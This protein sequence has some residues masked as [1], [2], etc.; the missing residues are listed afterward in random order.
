M[1]VW[2]N[3]W[4]S[5]V[6][7]LINL[8]KQG[9]PNKFTVIGS[10]ENETVVYKNA[11]DEWYTEPRG[12]TDE[13]YV[14]F[15]LGFCKEHKIDVFAPRKKLLAISKSYDRFKELGVILMLDDQYPLLEMLED[16]AR[17]YEY[18]AQ[19]VPECVPSFGIARSYGEFLSCYEE[20]SKTASRVCYKLVEDEGARSFRVVDNRIEGI[21]ALLEKPG[22]KVTLDTA[23]KILSQYD[24]K[25]P[26]LLMPYLSGVEVS[27]DC[28]Q[29]P[30][31]NIII[32]RY[33]TNK[34]YS[35]IIFD[36]KMMS[37]CNKILDSIA[38]KSP[39]NIQFK[40]EGDKFYL[41][42]INPRMSGGLQ[43]SCE[44]TGINLPDVAINKAIG[45]NKAWKYP[46]FKSQRVVHIET[47]IRL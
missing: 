14:D 23:K 28:L 33:K 42:E 5:T 30:G 35:E 1:R 44:A 29:T 36:E 45:E 2:F 40:F 18:F 13:E 26:L 8:I 38:L 24:F 19:I 9:S 11:C 27:V 37:V 12:L 4:F 32:P 3:H 6:F 41:L 20:L 17:T 7:H 39:L 15:C 43:L 34:R 16:K 25:V 10:N 21:N 46:S 47:P 22:M 31:E